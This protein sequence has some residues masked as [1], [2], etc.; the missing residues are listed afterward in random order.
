MNVDGDLHEAVW[1]EGHKYTGF[2]QPLFYPNFLYCSHCSK[3]W[4]SIKNCRK[5]KVI[6]TDKGKGKDIVTTSN[7]NPATTQTNTRITHQVGPI[8]RAT[9]NLFSNMPS[10]SLENAIETEDNSVLQP[11]DNEKHQG[12]IPE[13]AVNPSPEKSKTSPLPPQEHSPLYNNKF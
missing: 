1:I 5:R 9:G 10:G 2:W 12:T 7:A 6:N 8:Y 4:H 3:I 11:D 13:T